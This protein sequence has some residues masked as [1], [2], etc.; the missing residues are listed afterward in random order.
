MEKFEVALL[1]EAGF[2]DTWKGVISLVL[3]ETSELCSSPETETHQHFTSWVMRV[4]S[5]PSHQALT[6]GTEEAVDS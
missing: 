3:Q 5:P 1:L 2:S 4:T 6:G